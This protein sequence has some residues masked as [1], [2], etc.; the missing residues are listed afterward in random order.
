MKTVR[1]NKK[2]VLNGIVCACLLISM[3]LPMSFV[4]AADAGSG[5]TTDIYV[6]KE[7]IEAGTKITEDMLEKKT[8]KKL[9]IPSN[10]VSDPAKVVGTYAKETLYAGEYIY[11]AQTSKSAP[12]VLNN[13]LLIQNIATSKTPFVNVTEYFPANTGKDVGGLIQ[14]LIDKNPQATIYFPDGEYIVSSPI[15][16]H[17]DGN[18]ANSLLLA[19]G[20]VIKADKDNWKP[21]TAKNISY[22]PTGGENGFIGDI[23]MSAVISLGGKDLANKVND[24]RRVGSYYYLMGGTIDGNGVANGVS[25]DWGRESLVRNVTIQNFKRIGL[26]CDRGANGGSSDM[27]IEDVVII[28]NGSTN[29]T[30]IR[31]HAYDNTISG[32]RIYDCQN[33]VVNVGGGNIYRDIRIYFTAQDDHAITKMPDNLVGIHDTNNDNFYLHCYVENYAIAYKIQSSSNG[34]IDGCKAA[35][36]QKTGKKQIAFA[37]NG[38][39]LNATLSNCSAMFYSADTTNYFI[40]PAA[41]GNGVEIEMPVV[42]ES[43]LDDTTFKNK[44]K[45]NIIPIR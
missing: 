10:A 9:N 28:G 7:D 40:D 39:N 6:I 3:M 2:R 37:S 27:D 15:R 14:Q 45:G 16:T 36:T 19:D 34:T 12:T 5:E 8:F 42:D 18:K 30:G 33:G 38:G 44:V 17:S 41:C 31:F 24:T 20:A 22:K 11:V 1:N 35:W 23:T 13:D 29:T 25:I 32:C 4:A 26:E 43:L 21:Y